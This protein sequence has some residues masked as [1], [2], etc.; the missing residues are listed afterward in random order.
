MNWLCV[1]IFSLIVNGATPQPADA[2]KWNT[3]EVLCGKLIRSEEIPIKG[4]PNS[5]NERSKPIKNGILR[6]YLRNEETSCCEGQQPIAETVSGREG[7]FQFKKAAPHAYWI[8]AMVESKEYKLA[9][10]YAP[11]SKS[12]ANCSDVLY[13]VKKDQLQLQ[14]VVVV[15]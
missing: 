5:F 12:G 14:R 9:I 8:V 10:T 6:L 3:V 15:D 1:L 2:G 7:G 11:E 4:S 13:A